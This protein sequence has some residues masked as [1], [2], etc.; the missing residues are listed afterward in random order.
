MME[1]EPPRRDSEAQ[2]L[3]VTFHAIGSFPYLCIV[4][5]LIICSLVIG[6]W[7]LGLHPLAG[8]LDPHYQM[9]PM[10][11]CGGLFLGSA[12]IAAMR[13]ARLRYTLPAVMIPIAAFLFALALAII[14]FPTGSWLPSPDHPGI[15]P[16]AALSMLAIATLLAIKG[17]R[18]S[19]RHAV[20]LASLTLGIAMISGAAI[21][22]G[23]AGRGDIQSHA[24]M[25]IPCAT[26]TV[27]L[28]I[29]LI[30]WRHR[31]GW[32]GLPWNREI[33]G[34]T[35]RVILALCIF[36]PASFALVRLWAVRH[37]AGAAEVAEVVHVGAQIIVS[38]AILFWAWARISGEYAARWEITGALDSAPI[39][40]TNMDGEI[41]H[42]SQGCE[43]LY[44]W[45]AAEAVGR[46]KHELLGVGIPQRWEAMTRQLLRG[47]ACEEEIVEHRRDGTPLFI[48]EQAR[49]VHGAADR[50]PRIVLSMTDITARTRAEE[51]LRASDARLALAVEAHE[52]GIFE[53][54]RA[55]NA[56]SLS[57]VAETLSGLAPGSFNGSLSAWRQHLETIFELE[58]IPNEVI[59]LRMRIPR[60]TFRLN[61]IAAG[62]GA[63][64]I[65]GAARCF[66]A[67]DGTLTQMIGV[68][69]DA[70]EREQRAIELQ[71]REAELRSILETVPDAMVT[72]DEQGTIRS[73]SAAAEQLLGYRVDQVIGRK[74]TT[75]MPPRYRNG[76]DTQLQGYLR[77]AGPYLVGKART[78]AALHRDGTE[79]PIELAVGEAWIG[80]ERI[81]IG[82]LRDLTERFAAQ[83]RMTELRE[84]LLHVSRLSAMGEMAAGLA[85]ELNQP[86]AATTNFLGA[87]DMLLS[88]EEVDADQVRELMRLAGTQALRAGEIIKRMRGFSARG[89]VEIRAERLTDVLSDAIDLVLT[90]GEWRRAQV[91]FAFD[92]GRPMIMADRVQIQQVIVNLVRNALEALSDHPDVQPEI[93]IETRAA[94]KGM[95]EILVHDNGPGIAPE[96]LR[97]QHEPFFSTKADGMGI[98]LSICRRIVELH[99]GALIVE[100]RLKEGATMRFTVPGVDDPAL[101]E[102]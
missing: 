48:L 7:V 26:V 56:L 62:D 45:T 72:M 58:M 98:G 65:E 21:P 6:A 51:A 31:T 92:P 39:A 30:S 75:L 102:A 27:A 84:E 96:V 100:N 20:L 18:R 69:F 8:L 81:F 23:M 2:G 35:L 87:A 14:Q 83:A 24:P 29:A 49:I 28:S 53:W 10:T 95:V 74:V 40:L 70:T 5:A 73:F 46:T 99:G 67:P 15:I 38:A 93:V 16:A 33:E 34:R 25:S 97:R 66:Y 50:E 32:P 43:R 64:A 52:I 86:L 37:Y 11:A 22:L 57:P 13:G 79:I 55:G 41:I 59:G 88:D 1:L 61:R 91:R 85:H 71:A 3:E 82:F 68:M 54:E 63:R 80:Q 101:V 78:F 36:T 94:P 42:W 47:I 9:L 4:I 44:Q 19:S 76:H 77:A 12:M 90:S 60:L 17:G 89:I